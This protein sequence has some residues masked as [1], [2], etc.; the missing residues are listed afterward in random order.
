MVLKTAKLVVIPEITQD[1][2]FSR[3]ISK[4][5]T[6]KGQEKNPQDKMNCFNFIQG[7]SVVVHLTSCT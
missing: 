5:N 3:Q 6:F 7:W 2:K 4:K 1:F